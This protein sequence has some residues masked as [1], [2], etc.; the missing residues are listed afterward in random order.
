M[1]KAWQG[2]RQGS[3][4]ETIVH[5]QARDNGGLTKMVTVEVIRSDWILDIF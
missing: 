1:G 2:R 4:E 3:R 5:I